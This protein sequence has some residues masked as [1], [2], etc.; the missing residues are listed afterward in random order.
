MEQTVLYHLIKQARAE[1]KA[2]KLLPNVDN[3]EAQ[4]IIEPEHEVR[5]EEYNIISSDGCLIDLSFILGAVIIPNRE[6]RL[7]EERKR[8]KEIW[9]AYIP[10][11]KGK[12][13]RGPYPLKSEGKEYVG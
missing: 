7:K 5:N 8:Q 2:V 10:I 1:N 3:F 13:T 12:R 6:E 4:L 9:E 11:P